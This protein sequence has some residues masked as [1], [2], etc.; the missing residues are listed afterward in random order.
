MVAAAMIEKFLAVV[1][2]QRHN[3]VLP[4]SQLSQRPHQ[5]GY[6]CIHPANPSV[7][8]SDYFCAMPVQALRSQIATVPV[9]IQISRPYSIERALSHQF[10]RFLPRIVW[11]MRIHHV[12]PQEK[13]LT[14]DARQPVAGMVNDHVGGRKAP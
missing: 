5:T 3:A 7:V 8:E 6:L 2:C 10:E 9:R 14:G 4:Q 1:G 13:W 12:Q 11:R